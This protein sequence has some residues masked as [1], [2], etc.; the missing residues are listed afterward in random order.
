MSDWWYINCLQNPTKAVGKG[1]KVY[2]V[3]PRLECYPYGPWD[4][5]THE[6]Q[7]MVIFAQAS[8]SGQASSEPEDMTSYQFPHLPWKARRLESLVCTIVSCYPNGVYR[9]HCFFYTRIQ[10]HGHGTIKATSG[11]PM[12]GMKVPSGYWVFLSSF[13]CHQKFAPVSGHICA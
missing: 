11:G 10:R 9:A 4:L 12:A 8:K 7:D 5:F 2:P 6:L 1:K 3:K 13:Y